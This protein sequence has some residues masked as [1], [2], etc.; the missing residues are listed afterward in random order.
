MRT[1]RA[2]LAAAVACLAMAA[3]VTPAFADE[4]VASFVS[5][6]KL[7]PPLLTVNRSSRGQAPGYIFTAVFQNKFF[8]DPLV[9]QGGSMIV[10]GKGH[11]VW[12]KPAT[13]SAPDTLNLQVQRYRGK[14]VLTYW[15]GTVQNTGEMAG[16]WHVLNDRY[17]QITTISGKDGWDLSG[18][19]FLITKSGTALVTGY[20]HMQHKDLRSAGGGPDQTLLDS[21]V[22]EYDLSNGRLV[23]VWSAADHLPMTD[24]YPPANPNSPIAYDP[25]HINSIDVAADGTWLVSLRN[26]WAIYKIDPT[27]GA[28]VWILG[29]KR[30][31]FAVPSGVAWAFQHDARWL[32]NGQIS[33]FDNDCCAFIPQPSG[34]PKPAPP[35]HGQQ[36]RGL[37]I[38]LD[39]AAR[40]VAFV[41][42]NKLYDLTA[43]T[44]GNRQ[45]LP[46]GN[47]F[48]GWGQQP[49]FSE[50]T[51]TGKLLLSVR[52]PD[53]D[54]SYRAYRFRWTGHPTGRPAAAARPSGKRTRVYMS[55]NGA[56]QVAAY[57]IFAGK[58]SHRLNVAAKRV[59]KGGFETAKTIRSAGPVVKVQALDAKGRVLGTSRAVRRQNTSG[60]TPVPIY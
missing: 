12:L 47:V 1:S 33:M 59:R 60:T 45:S 6:P 15:D 40:T 9:C 54:E 16:T 58:S 7:K 19:E 39:E 22:L 24:G 20:R 34:P 41:A 28:V 31:D 14:P 52:F 8:T 30:S 3:A 48:M 32:P 21:G 4:G 18:H 43:G 27:T 26:T 50:F 37:V 46:N 10:D 51:K 55:W 25:W 13:R 44:Q 17:K 53:P 36:S 38:K 11:Y 5:A 42:E 56:T 23:K 49:F 29:G 2:L 35:V 57:R